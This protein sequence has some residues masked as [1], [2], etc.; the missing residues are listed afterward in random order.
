MERVTTRAASGASTTRLALLGAGR[1]GTR[2]A[3]AVGRLQ[4]VALVG[5]ADPDRGASD[6]VR[7]LAPTAVCADALPDLL[8]LRPHAVLVATPPELHAEHAREILAARC[9]LFVEKPLATC[10]ADARELAQAARSN[11]CVAMVGHVLRF[12]PAYERAQRFVE[13]GA[14]GTPISFHARRLTGSRSPSALWA[15]APHDLATLHAIDPSEVVEL[16]VRPA[17][18]SAALGAD[19]VGERGVELEL[20]LRSGLTAH[21][22]VATAATVPARGIVLVGSRQRVVVDELCVARTFWHEPIDAAAVPD[23]EP[24]RETLPGVAGDPLLAELAHF[25]RAIEQR[26][27]PRCSFDEGQWVVETIER[28]HLLLGARAPRP[29]ARPPSGYAQGPRQAPRP[30]PGRSPSAPQ[31]PPGGISDIP[32]AR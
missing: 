28:A 29:S 4:G 20:R 10:A 27:V 8:A 31:S 19:A 26:S 21:L 16:T 11:G 14:L 22:L 23:E 25:V 13:Q 7:R 5:V 17:L 24:S 18:A 32:T 30:G 9:D 12:H 1:W 2:L 15:L 3:A 6:R